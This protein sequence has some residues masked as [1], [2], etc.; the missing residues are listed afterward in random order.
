MF[1]AGMLMGGAF[2]AL[3]AFAGA[4]WMV[5]VAMRVRCDTCGV[6]A[7]PVPLQTE[8]ME[9]GVR[10]RRPDPPAGWRKLANGD[11]QCAACANRQMM[12][13]IGGVTRVGSTEAG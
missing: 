4:V 2:V 5:T 9:H 13:S 7:P 10:L 8:R 11:D 3:L 1:I 12:R 6:M